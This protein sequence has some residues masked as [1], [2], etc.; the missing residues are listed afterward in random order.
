MSRTLPIPI[1]INH[2]ILFG[3]KKITDDKDYDPLE[4]QIRKPF[5]PLFLNMKMAKKEDCQL[6]RDL[7]SL[8]SYNTNTN[9]RL[10]VRQ[11]GI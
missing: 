2:D 10:F 8:A 9:A 11:T 5:R 1:E 7:R 4:E 6:L 3:K